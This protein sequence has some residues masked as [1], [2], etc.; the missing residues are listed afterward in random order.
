[1]SRY[2]TN[3]EENS[4]RF[5]NLADKLATLL[6]HFD[7]NIYIIN[8][9]NIH[10]A[11]NHPEYVQAW[12]QVIYKSAPSLRD[13]FYICRLALLTII[14]LIL[15][16]LKEFLSTLRHQENS[17]N[18]ID[19]EI[20]C[21]FVSHYIGVENGEIDFYYGEILFDLAKKSKKIVRLLI[22]HTTQI[23]NL[24]PTKSYQSILLNEKLN[25]L[26]ILKYLIGNSRAFFQLLFFCVNK[27]YTIYDTTNILIGQLSNFINFKISYNISSILANNKIHKL[28]MTYEGNSIEKSL[29][30]LCSE[31]NVLSAGFQ[32]APIIK[33]Q[34]AIFTNL[35]KRLS[36]AAILTSGPYLQSKFEIFLS[37][38]IPITTLGSPKFVESKLDIFDYSK[39][40]NVLLVPDGNE[41]SVQTF[42][43]LGFNLSKKLPHIKIFMRSHP[44][45]YYLLDNKF[46]NLL[47]KPDNFNFSNKTV[48]NDLFLTNWV[49]YQNSSVCVQAIMHGCRVIYL[50][51]R[52]AN[53][54]P[55]FE[56]KYNHHTA[57]ELNDIIRTLEAESMN[58]FEAAKLASSFASEY[59]SPINSSIL[60]DFF[61]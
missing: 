56:L 4:K 58:G 45:F 44:L 36:P 34:H 51:H 14:S 31:F 1:M 13:H 19:K 57:R 15:A 46:Q 16:I 55:L 37:N 12:K 7:D 43:K 10:L 18:L 39:N 60:I 2:D 59:F 40:H 50:E 5:Y 30:Y 35:G 9:P 22:P 21:I 20:D 25:I 27:N 8:N 6:R 53:I 52:L 48:E 47:E 29:F 61:D 24:V 38:E 28:I 41:E 26:V 54:D 3:R 17:Q 33:D 32:H 11:R 42:F 23:V 49:I